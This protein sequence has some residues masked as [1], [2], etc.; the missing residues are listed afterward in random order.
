MDRRFGSDSVA[1]RGRALRALLDSAPL[2]SRSTVTTALRFALAL[3]YIWFGALKLVHASDVSPL[4]DATLP[5]TAPGWF[6]PAMGVL[7]IAIGAVFIRGRG[8]LL[9]LPLFLAHMAGTFASLAM[10]PQL[11]FHHGNP[12]L[13]T[14]TGEFVVKNLVLVAAGVLVT[15]SPEPLRPPQRS[16]A[17]PTVFDPDALNPAMLDR[18]VLKPSSSNGGTPAPAASP[19]MRE[20]SAPH[21][22]RRTPAQSTAR[23]EEA[24]AARALSD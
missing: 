7:E 20:A 19:A 11:A 15:L 17:A 8:L 2:P 1:G 6:I 14:L 24:P 16:A 10:A 13:L 22:V 4:I 18:S 9:L 5:F 21:P 3:V 23:T 12:F